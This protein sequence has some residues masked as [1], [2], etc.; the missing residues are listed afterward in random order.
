MFTPAVGNATLK[1]K[2][3]QD[4]MFTSAVGNAT[5]KLKFSPDAM[6]TSAVEILP[7]RDVHVCRG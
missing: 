6:F 3:S 7:G 4:A 5:L 2:F 1:L